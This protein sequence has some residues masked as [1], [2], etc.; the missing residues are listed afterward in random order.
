MTNGE[1]RGMTAESWYNK[2]NEYRRRSDWQHAI[3]CYMEAIELDPNSPAVEA[4][5]MLE[6]ILNFYDKNA[7][8]P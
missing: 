4:K 2:G 8:N 1:T 7:Y 3:N 5:Q 6:S